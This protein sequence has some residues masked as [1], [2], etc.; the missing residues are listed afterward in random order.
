MP[1]LDFAPFQKARPKSAASPKPS[2]Q[3]QPREPWDDMVSTPGRKAIITRHIDLTG[4]GVEVGPILR[5]VL[6]REEANVLYADYVDQETL[7]AE[8]ANNPRVDTARIP[9][10]DFV[11]GDKFLDEVAGTD[12]FD[13]IIASHVIEH[14]PDLIG[15]VASC[16][17]AL[18]PGGVLSL[19]IPNANYTFDI[20]RRRTEFSDLLAA[21]VEQRK[22]PTL[23]QVADHFANSCKVFAKDV[24]SGVTTPENVRPIYTLETTLAILRKVNRSGAYK[25]CH[26]WVFDEA[27]FEACIEEA[28]RLG[29]LQT[30]IVEIV[31]TMPRSPEFFASLRRV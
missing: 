17:R 25:N 11:I 26:C 2:P 1:K 3:P 21:H 28:I 18:K 4:T 9:K 12:R 16:M 23:T 24:W 22:K 29:L 27:R 19:A 6:S 13:Y 8:Y 5:L 15:W 10:I 31:K 14:V 30:E 7:R 20:R